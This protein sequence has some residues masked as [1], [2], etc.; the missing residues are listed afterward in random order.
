MKF[1]NLS[2]T[3]DFLI[4]VIL[5]REVGG[6]NQIVNYGEERGQDRRSDTEEEGKTGKPA[7]HSTQKPVEA[8]ARPIRNHGG[9]RDHVFDPLM[10]SGTTIIA[11][12]QLGRRCHGAEINTTYT[13]VCVLRWQAFTGKEATLE[14]DGR[15]FNEIANERKDA[16][17][18]DDSSKPIDQTD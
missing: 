10:G 2:G 16:K 12:E 3:F 18:P 17:A 11:C 7:G 9:K 13:D 15:T 14:A 8:M 1:D 5:P 6:S 4:L